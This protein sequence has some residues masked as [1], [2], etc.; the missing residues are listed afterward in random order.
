MQVGIVMCKFKVEA[1]L[2]RCLLVDHTRLEFFSLFFA[3]SFGLHN[4]I[5]VEE[6]AQNKRFFRR[7]RVHDL[8]WAHIYI[9]CSFPLLPYKASLLS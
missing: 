7:G 5:L 6:D 2:F 3:V 4:S 1:R 9:Y 8:L